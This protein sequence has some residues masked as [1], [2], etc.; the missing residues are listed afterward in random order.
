[1]LKSA[2]KP[3]QTNKSIGISVLYFSKQEFNELLKGLI[4]DED[5]GETVGQYPWKTTED[6]MLLLKEKV[7]LH[8]TKSFYWN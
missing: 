2:F 5:N 1:L 6:E 3:N 8:I 7:C 4:L